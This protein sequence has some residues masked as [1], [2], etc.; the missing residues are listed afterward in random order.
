MNPIVILLGIVIIVLIYVLYKYFSSNTVTLQASGSLNAPIPPITSI[1]SPTNTRYGYG[2]WLFVN[3]WDSSTTSRIVFNRNNNLQ[4]SFSQ[5]SP[6]L[7]C[8][9]TMSD[10]NTQTAMITDNFPLQKWVYVIISVDNQFMDAYLDGKLVVS[11]RFF[12]QSTPSVI[13]KQPQDSTVPITLGN[14]GMPNFQK[15]D[16]YITRFQRWTDPVDPQTAW[17]TYMSGNGGSTTSTLGAYSAN[18]SILQNNVETNKYT[19]F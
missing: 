3:S 2:I 12:N 7:N 13:P 18:L 11:K 19:L 14:S 10:G 17:N 9:M 6:T 15:Q 4:L 5:S 8:I 1:N 16:I